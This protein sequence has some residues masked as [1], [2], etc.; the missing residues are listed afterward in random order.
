MLIFDVP[1]PSKIV[2]KWRQKHLQNQ[3]YVG[4][5]LGTLK[6]TIF[7][8][9]TS[10]RWLPKVSIFSIIAYETGF[11]L[12]CLFEASKNLPRPSQEPPQ[13][14]PGAA[15]EPSRASPQPSR[16]SLQAPKRTPRACFTDLP[17]ASLTSHLKPAPCHASHLDHARHVQK[18]N[19]SGRKTTFWRLSPLP[20]SFQKPSG[21]MWAA[22]PPQAYSII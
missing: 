2:P 6:N 18:W 7:D 3:L 12:S 1:R 22:V 14:L 5:S 13:S 19:H 20:K 8:V 9:K 17:S 21:N 4:Y 15:P 10:P 11:G 16:A